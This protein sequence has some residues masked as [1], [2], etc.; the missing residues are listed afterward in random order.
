MI[1]LQTG[2]NQVGF[3]ESCEEN[4][5]STE[6]SNSVFISESPVM[7]IVH[8]KIRGLAFL[9]SPVLILGAGGTGR[10]TAALEI[11]NGND[12]NFSRRFIKFV[13]YGLDQDTIDKKLFGEGCEDGLLKSGADNTLFIK[14]IEC[15]NPLLQKKFLS[16]LLNHY[17][18]N[19]L[20]RLIFSSS[21][22]LSQKVKDTQFSQDLFKI[23]SQNLLILPLLSERSEDIPLLISLFNEQ[24]G[25][26]GHMTEKA[27]QTLSFHS[28]KGNITELK[29]LCL[30][31][32]I[33]CPDKKSIAKED[34]PMVR[35]KHI[36]IRNI[37]NYNPNVK[38]ESLIN[39]YIQMS[40]DHFQSKQKSAKALGISVKTIYNKIKTGCVVFSD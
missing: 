29:N 14:G 24:N 37:M 9:S 25:F 32:S 11:F 13:C 26:T 28:W 7:K 34:L 30:Q 2:Q 39:H 31:I 40:L 35:K 10:T 20:P 19:A 36:S 3:Q 17:E 12:S 21:E 15:F 23:L 4:F 8:E 5:I 16:Y 27:L 22:E 18:K 1:V 38:L 6:L 33:L